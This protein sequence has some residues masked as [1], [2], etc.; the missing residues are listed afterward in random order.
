MRNLRERVATN[1]FLQDFVMHDRRSELPMPAS[2]QKIQVVL[3]DGSI[4]C[5]GTLLDLSLS[6]AR[7][8]IPLP[9]EVGRKLDLIF[10]DQEQRFCS[11]VVWATNTEIGISF[12]APLPGQPLAARG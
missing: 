4:A 9:I 5:L 3:I 8:R 7:L 1:S 2:N 11:T 12:D 10:D 6:G